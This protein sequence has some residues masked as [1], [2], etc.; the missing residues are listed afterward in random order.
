MSMFQSVS[1]PLNKTGKETAMTLFWWL[2]A[3]GVLTVADLAFFVADM[4]IVSFFWFLGIVV[5]SYFFV[6]GAAE[7]LVAGDWMHFLTVILPLYLL[8]GAGV[9]MVKWILN[10]AKH[11]LWL[12]EQWTEFKKGSSGQSTEEIR[13]DFLRNMPSDVKTDL[14]YSFSDIRKHVTH[15]EMTELLTPK[16]KKN[17]DKITFWALQW[18][19]TIIG[20][21]LKD[22]LL[23]IGKHLARLFDFLFHGLAKQIVGAGLK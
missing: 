6:P 16:A 9:S 20:T 1:S 15:E 7:I 8:I 21:L 12:N 18:P 22:I 17:I 19:V 14:G 5:G 2:T 10:V 13:A 3:L 11:G 4:Y 23:K